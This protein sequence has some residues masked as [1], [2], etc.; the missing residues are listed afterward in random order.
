MF[1]PSSLWEPPRLS[2]LPSMSATKRLGIDTETRDPQL[3]KLGP[4]VRRDGKV[5]GISLAWEDGPAHYLPIGHSEGNLPEELVWEYMREQA[6]EYDGIVVGANLQY[7]LDYLAQNG[8]V[9]K[10]AKWFRDVQIAEPLIDE[11]QSS[12]SLQAI[13]ERHGLPGKDES[14][15]REA[16]TA[17]GLDP[18]KEMYKLPSRFVGDYATRDAELPLKLLRRQERML[19]DMELWQIYDLE[20]K[21]LPILVKMR[22]KGVRISWDR[23]DQ[24][25]QWA[26]A[27]ARK[28][29]LR[30][31]EETGVNLDWRDVWKPDAIARPL[32]ETGV[33][34]EKRKDG[35]HSV[36][37][38]TLE[39]LD[40]AG[41][42]VAKHLSRARQMNKVSTTFAESLR[43]HAVGD[44]IHGSFNQLRVSKGEG[45]EDKGARYGRLS[46]TD[47]NMQQ[48][49]ARHP[50]IGPRWRSV[51]I[52]DE[53]G[54]WAA[55]DYSQ[56]EPRMLTHFAELCHLPK[57]HA[58]AERY[59]TD[60]DADNHDMM[61]EL[62]HGEGLRE[63]IS[64]AEFKKLR[65]DAK[66]IFLGK[67]YGMGGGKLC[68][69]LGLP[70][71]WV[72]SNKRNAMIEVAGPEGQA[73]IDKFDRELP[74]VAG[75][76]ERCQK[77]ADRDGVLKTILGRRCHF[78]RK[79]NGE[80]DWTHKALNRLIQGSSADQTKAAMIQVAAA[81]FDMGLQVHDEIDLTVGSVAEAEEVARIMRECVDLRVPSK[82]DVEIGPS[83]GEA[84]ELKTWRERAAAGDESS[85]KF[86]HSIGE[87]A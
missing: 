44:R 62:I 29:L 66:I 10:K 85:V 38:A 77:K 83:W 1:Q 21:L 41:N 80:F 70:T 52:P 35:K 33:E 32:L 4:G 78:P 45:D 60:P 15:L 20:S 12:Y 18:K 14:A 58:M 47:P 63:R 74:F 76:A 75:L 19:E 25:E 69:S 5:V 11:L 64:K 82:V 87:A 54:I 24:V 17:W 73:I 28:A 40:R 46:S 57:A 50:E 8:V 43:K 6:A 49:P 16:A 7:D 27:E 31:K 51:Y 23:L 65:G 55:N 13:S 71:E 2:E 61:T 79:A 68:R 3:K 53:G 9:F 48:Q 36:D 84:A 81:G 42:V 39:S 26:I 86:L 56:Q 37:K 22:R 72:W 30:V 34:L 67:C 59:R